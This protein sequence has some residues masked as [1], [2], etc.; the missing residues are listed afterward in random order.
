M[1]N[2]KKPSGPRSGDLLARSQ[3]GQQKCQL[4]AKK[5]HRQRP[6]YIHTYSK[7]WGGQV[8]CAAKGWS[9][10]K[11]LKIKKRQAIKMAYNRAN[12]GGKSWM[13][14]GT[15]GVRESRSGNSCNCNCCCCCG[16]IADRMQRTRP[17]GRRFILGGPSGPRPLTLW[18]PNIAK[19]P[20]NVYKACHS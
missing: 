19:W 13:G 3:H 1:V 5:G 6:F 12:K 2:S 15:W 7:D 4:E 20:P 18:G 8:G 11:E 16:I 10:T 17:L 9:I 14:G